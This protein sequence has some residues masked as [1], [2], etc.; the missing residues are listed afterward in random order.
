MS[1]VSDAKNEPKKKEGILERKRDHL[2]LAARS[3]M[4]LH[5]AGFDA[6]ELAYCAL[7]EIALA[8]VDLR[9]AF[10]RRELSFPLL[11]GSM[12]GGPVEAGAFNRVLARAAQKERVA[13]GL[14]SIRVAIEHPEVLPTFQVRREAPDIP[15][16][17]NLGAVQLNKGITE[18][19]IQDV[20]TRTESDALIL[21]L[22]P[23][24]EAIQPEGDTDFSDLLRKIE[25]LCKKLAVPV[26]AKEVGAGISG[27]M[28][29][30]LTEVGVHIIDV[31]GTGGTSWA[32][33]EGARGA[34]RLGQTFAGWGVSSV[35]ALQEAV[36]ACPPATQ[37]IAGGGIRT[38]LDM[39]KAVA[40]GAHLT[41]LARPFLLAYREGKT[42][43][44]AEEKVRE[45]I[46]VLRREMQIACFCTGVH[47]L[48]ELRVRG[49]GVPSVQKTVA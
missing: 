9:T 47:T 12:S 25:H 11:V 2:T 35:R 19:Q 30:R 40:M 45:F 28:A 5:A 3:D 21:H 1:S 42:E 37:L 15:L 41:T 17:V 27:I 43:E 34:E 10:L 14:G 13:L 7:P 22:N 49:L 44:E 4:D 23:L 36:Q 20:I 29:K 18:T 38:G 48:E 24:Q 6:V 8:E 26:M 16:L 46:A 31:S 32:K 33:I 39:A